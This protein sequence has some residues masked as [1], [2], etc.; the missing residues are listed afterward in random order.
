MHLLERNFGV[1]AWSALATLTPVD[2]GGE[3][4]TLNHSHGRK[5]TASSQRPADCRSVSSANCLQTRKLT[6]CLAAQNIKLF[7]QDKWRARNDSNVRP[8]D[9]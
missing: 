1:A 8:S 5:R 2:G 9:S 4:G 3:S 6:S 7:Q